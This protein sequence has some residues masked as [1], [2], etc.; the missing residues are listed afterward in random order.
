MKGVEALHG[1][2]HYEIHLKLALLE[3][4]P[5]RALHQ[6]ASRPAT[7]AKPT[8]PDKK[9]RTLKALQ[10]P[11]S[12]F[13]QFPPTAFKFIGETFPPAAIVDSPARC[14]WVA[15]RIATQNQVCAALENDRSDVELSLNCR[16]VRNVADELGP[17]AL[18]VQFSAAP[19]PLSAL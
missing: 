13:V 11:P 18:V 9:Y 12:N 16:R 3:R 7:E 6:V 1:N 4:F 14:C 2:L 15:V 8:P 5:A 10:K 17:E 19:E